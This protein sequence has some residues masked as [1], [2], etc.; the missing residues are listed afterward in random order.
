MALD[1]DHTPRDVIE[2]KGSGWGFRFVGKTEWAKISST[3]RW[4]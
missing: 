3:M 2:M 1:D 4:R